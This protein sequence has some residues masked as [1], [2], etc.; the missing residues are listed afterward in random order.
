M[1]KVD[2]TQLAQSVARRLTRDAA[3]VEIVVDALIEEIYQALKRE[4]SINLRHLGT[5]Y[6]DVRRTGTVFKFNPSQR[7]RALF[8]WS[9]TYK[10]DL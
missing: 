7:L 1:S 8:G 2:K 3:D 4:E 9:S 6:I 10:G 5:F